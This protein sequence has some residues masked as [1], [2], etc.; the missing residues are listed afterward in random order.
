SAGSAAFVFYLVAYTPT[1]PAAFAL[2]PAKGR[3]G[4]RDVLT[5]DLG[6]LAHGRPWL[7]FA[8]AMS[9]LP[10][11]GVLGTAGFIGRGYIPRPPRA[12]RS[13]T[14]GAPRDAPRCDLSRVRH[15][16]HRGRPAHGR[17]RA[18]HRAGGR[19]ARLGALGA[20]RAPARRG[21]GQ[22]PLRRRARAGRAL[23]HRS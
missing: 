15:P 18:R 19:D 21:A 20:P 14:P 2:L 23:G 4:E 10:L 7:V 6:G 22:P 3:G 8:A 11:L 16:R 5:D 13:L 12:A 17:R 1:P 9:M